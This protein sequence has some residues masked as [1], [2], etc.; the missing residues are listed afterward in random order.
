MGLFICKKIVEDH[1]GVIGVES[2]K[3]TGNTFYLVLPQKAQAA[4]R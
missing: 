2:D 3:E 4:E 1:L